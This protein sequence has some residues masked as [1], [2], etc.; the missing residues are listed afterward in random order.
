MAQPWGLV[1]LDAVSRLGAGGSR[2]EPCAEL[3]LRE[4]WASA[5]ELGYRG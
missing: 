1:Q 5:A 3:G 2:W 4:Q